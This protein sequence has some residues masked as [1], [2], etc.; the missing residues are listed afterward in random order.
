MK[1]QISKNNISKMLQMWKLSHAFLDTQWSKK[2]RK[3]KL[4]K[5]TEIH[6]KE[7]IVQHWDVQ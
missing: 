7:D 6:M 4:G 5:C 3:K 2:E 1:V